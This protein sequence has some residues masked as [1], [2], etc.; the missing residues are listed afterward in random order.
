VSHFF[1]FAG[2]FLLLIH[3]YSEI[4]LVST[5]S[6]PHMKT[7]AL[8]I[9]AANLGCAFGIIAENLFIGTSQRWLIGL[10][11]AIACVSACAYHEIRSRVWEGAY[12]F[13]PQEGNEGSDESEDSPLFFDPP[14]DL[15]PAAIQPP[16]II[17]SISYSCHNIAHHFA[18]SVREEEVLC[19]LVRGKS[20][21]SMAQ[22][23]YVSYNT[24]KTHISHVYKKLDRH[25]R[26]ELIQLVESYED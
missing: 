21:K 15:D 9:M 26:E 20:A 5:V 13:A 17:D 6:Q 14:S 18:L 25:T 2:S 7:F 19:Y 23:M 12:T 16:S 22:E 8:G 1:I 10:I 11:Y 24:V 4:D 3:L